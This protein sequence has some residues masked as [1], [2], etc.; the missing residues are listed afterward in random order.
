MKRR[1]ILT[2]LFATS[3]AGCGDSTFDWGDA[4]NRAAVS[5]YNGYAAGSMIDGSYYRR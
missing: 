4:F 5:F 3:V 1:L 2:L